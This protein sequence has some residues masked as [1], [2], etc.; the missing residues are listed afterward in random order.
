[1]VFRASLTIVL[2]VSGFSLVF[3]HG[4]M[5]DPAARNAA[6]RFGFPTPVQYTDDEL[7]CGGFGTQW[8]KNGGKCGTCGDPYDKKDPLYVYP[9]RYAKGIITKTYKQGQVFTVQIKVTTNHDGYFVFKI[10]KLEKP[11]ITEAGLS[12]RVYLADGSDRFR[13]PKKSPAKVFEIKL[14]LPANLVCQHCV[15]RWWWRAGNSWG[16]DDEGC[17]MGHGPQET[18][19]NCADVKIVE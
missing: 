14:K 10:G 8:Q 1:M 11:P 17:G 13:I 9:G 2:A 7:N 16:C 3:G 4:R 18:F 15:L 6:W 12:T 19:T 5:I